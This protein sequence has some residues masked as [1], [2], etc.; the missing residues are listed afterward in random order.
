MASLDFRLRKGSFKGA[1]VKATALP[2]G[3]PWVNKF[4]HVSI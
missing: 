3:L 4:I 1:I 2:G